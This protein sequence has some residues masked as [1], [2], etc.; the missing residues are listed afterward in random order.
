MLTCA[1]VAQENADVGA[2]PFWVFAFAIET[3]LFLV[4]ND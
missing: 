2:A 3:H 4:R 1:L